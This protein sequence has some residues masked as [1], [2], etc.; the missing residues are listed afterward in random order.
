MDE[1]AEA[2]FRA[3]VI[4]RQT[5]LLR[6]AYLLTGS[7]QTAEDLLQT[8]LT[9]TYLSWPRIR[10]K[11]AAESYVRTTMARTATSWWRRRWRGEQ[12]T[13][14]LPMAEATV[15]SGPEDRDE[16]WQALSLLP[17]RQRA[18]LVL[19]FYEDLTEVEIAAT[20]G[21]STGSVKTHA[22]RGLRTLRSR[23]GDTDAVDGASR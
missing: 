4:S 3:F 15:L 21:C 1:D 10:D 22:S 2:A 19:R 8:A 16:V 13:A 12:P 14:D 17:D 7:W 6:T 5:A 20:L 11:A 18:V 9:K 23:L